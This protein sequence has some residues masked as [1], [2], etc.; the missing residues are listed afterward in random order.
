MTKHLALTLFQLMCLVL[1]HLL[2]CWPVHPIQPTWAVAGLGLYGRVPE[3]NGSL[4][5][6]AKLGTHLWSYLVMCIICTISETLNKLIWYGTEVRR[7]TSIPPPDK[8]TSARTVVAIN[9]PPPHNATM[10][11]VKSI[12][13]SYGEVVWV[14]ILG[15]RLK[16]HQYYGIKELLWKNA[17]VGNNI[18]TLILKC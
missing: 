9:I 8:T 4:K 11:G 2:V 16:G 13:S 6:N 14:R 17:E 12:F 3:V 5:K 7:K 18:I 10:R 15:S 1:P